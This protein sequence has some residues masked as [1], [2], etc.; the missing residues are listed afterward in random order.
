MTCS[1]LANRIGLTALLLPCILT[2]CARRQPPVAEIPPAEVSLETP[3][4]ETVVDEYETTGRVAA[5]EYVELRPRVSGHLMQVDFQDGDE[6]KTGQLLFQIDPKPFQAALK[7]AEAE[8]QKYQA[9]VAKTQADLLRQEELFKNNIITKAE[10]ELSI[11]ERDVAR[12]SLAAATAALER[13]QLDIEYAEVKSPIDGRASIASIKLGNLVSPTSP[14]GSLLTTIVSV[15][16]MQVYFS[17]DERTVLKARQMRKVEQNVVDLKRIRDLGLKVTIF[18]EDPAA[19]RRRNHRLRRQ[20]DRQA[21][22]NHP[23]PGRSRQQI[24]APRRRHVC[25]RQAPRQRLPQR[26]HGPGP[27]HRHQP[28]HKVRLHRR[29]Q[30]HRTHASGPA[31]RP[32]RFIAKLPPP[33][34]VRPSPQTTESSSTACSACATATRSANARPIRRP[35]PRPQPPGP[36]RRAPR[37]VR[38]PTGRFLQEAPACSPPSLSIGRSSPPSSPW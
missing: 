17:V 25:S 11:A 30:G 9:T 38:I 20:P 16:P 37:P 33:K 8:V 13:S 14:G 36:D 29:R 24:P 26:P 6:V 2:G 27:R 22:R 3:T 21:D 1:S 35:P 32:P 5:K 28:R 12:A 10:I 23:T 15:D 34:V 19:A 18:L 31:R 7:Q 4:R